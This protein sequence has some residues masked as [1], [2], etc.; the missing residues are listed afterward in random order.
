MRKTIGSVSIFNNL[1]MFAGVFLITLFCLAGMEQLIVNLRKTIGIKKGVAFFIGFYVVLYVISC[2][3]HILDLGIRCGLTLLVI[4][5]VGANVHECHEKRGSDKKIYQIVTDGEW[6]I[7]SSVILLYMVELVDQN[8][9]NIGAEYI[10]GN[11]VIYLL[12]LMMVYMLVRSVFYSVSAVMFVMYIFSVA[13]SFVR[14]FRGSPIVLGDFLAVGTAKNVFM[15]YHYSVTGTMLLSL[16]LLIAFLFLTYYFYGRE[17]RAFSCV[18]VWSAPAA[19]MLGFV[20]GGSLFVPDMDFWNQNINVQRYGIALSFVSDIRHMKLDEPVGYS[21]KD[22]EKM[23][24]EFVETED[25][26]EESRPN[27]IAIMNESFGSQ[28]DFSG[29]G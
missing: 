27:V 16:W 5:A 2:Y 18:V 9:A 11:I 28:C 12:F 6:L 14:S 29:T 26:E 10:F 3:F 17:K 4:L 13:N 8:L 24:S 21:S 7:L 25:G 1:V 23:I 15:N 19:W 20:I 22:S